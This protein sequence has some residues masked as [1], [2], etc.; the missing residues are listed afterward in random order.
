VCSSDLEGLALLAAAALTMPL[1]CGALLAYAAGGHAPAAYAPTSLTA[2]GHGLAVLALGAAA[3]LA[4]PGAARAVLHP[5]LTPEGTEGGLYLASALA[6][7]TAALH[8][9]VNDAKA[10]ATQLCACATMALAWAY[11][12]LAKPKAAHVLWPLVAVYGLL[13]AL[14]AA[15]NAGG[16]AAAAKSALKAIEGARQAR[17]PPAG[18]AADA[19]TKKGK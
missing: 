4:P 10:A 17:A 6:L 3:L 15:E 7:G 18:A 14:G 5:L 2:L 8:A 1:A 12:A 19:E 9:G 16:R 13:A 11:A